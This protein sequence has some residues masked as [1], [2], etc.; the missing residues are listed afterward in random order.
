MEKTKDKEIWT[1]TGK[2]I[3]ELSFNKGGVITLAEEKSKNK[4][5]LVQIAYTT[6]IKPEKD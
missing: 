3:Q 4:T 1:R 2:T 6:I 5:R